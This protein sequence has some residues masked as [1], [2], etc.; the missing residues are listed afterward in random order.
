MAEIQKGGGTLG[1]LIYDPGV[2]E[3]LK[4]LLGGAEESRLLRYLVSRSVRE[5]KEAE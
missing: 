4:R 1:L 2:W 3:A 5:E